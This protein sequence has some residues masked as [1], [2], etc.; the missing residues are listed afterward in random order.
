MRSERLQR[1]IELKERLMEEKERLLDQHA[2]K[3]NA[4]QS[5]IEGLDDEIDGNYSDLCTRCL[6]GNE[7]TSL[8]EYLEHLKGM[9]AEALAQKALLEQKIAVIRAELYEMFKEIKTLDA[10]KKRTFSAAKRAENKKLQKLLDE[11]ALR[12]E[13]RKT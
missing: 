7:F 10:L 6:D 9:K 12:L 3:R 8:I 13:S 2:K 1:I 11:I 5:N 4:I